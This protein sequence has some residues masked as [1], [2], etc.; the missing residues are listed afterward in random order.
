CVNRRPQ[1]HR[2]AAIDSCIGATLD[3]CVV[4]RLDRQV[5]LGGRGGAGAPRLAVPPLP[6]RLAP[7]GP[8]SRACNSLFRRRQLFPRLGRSR[9]LVGASAGNGTVSGRDHSH[10]ARRELLEL[11]A[12]FAVDV[13]GDGAGVSSRMRR[14][15]LLVTLVVATV[16]LPFIGKW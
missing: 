1:G 2:R 12:V 9:V 10:A 3:P 7:T 5:I 6:L 4:C 8:G 11:L 13:A 14:S 16:I 15:F